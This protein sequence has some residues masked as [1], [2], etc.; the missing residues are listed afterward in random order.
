MEYRVA[1]FTT[2]VGHD[3][4]RIYNSLQ[5]EKDAHVRDMD[6]ILEKMK[7]YCLR[8]TNVYTNDI[9]LT[10]DLRNRARRLMS[11]SRTL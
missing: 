3:A 11:S 5:F 1:T 2:C 7:Q 6:K 9:S 10:K 8:E 4:L